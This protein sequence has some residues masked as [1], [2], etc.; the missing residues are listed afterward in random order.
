MYGNVEVLEHVI[1]IYIYIYRLK[2]ESIQVCNK[3]NVRPL[4]KRVTSDIVNT[5]KDI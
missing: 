1:Y 3:M 5:D 4:A 2:N